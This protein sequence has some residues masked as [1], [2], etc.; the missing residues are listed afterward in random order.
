MYLPEPD[1]MWLQGVAGIFLGATQGQ[2]RIYA[3]VRRGFIKLAMESGAGTP[4]QLLLLHAH[5][6]SLHLPVAALKDL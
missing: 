1:V 6:C 4:I 2:E 3:R 5:I